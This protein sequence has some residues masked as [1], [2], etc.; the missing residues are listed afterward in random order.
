[1]RYW[2]KIK[3]I[4]DTGDWLDRYYFVYAW[5]DTVNTGYAKLN[6]ALSLIKTTVN[7]VY[8]VTEIRI[9]QAITQSGKEVE[10]MAPK[11]VRLAIEEIYKTHFIL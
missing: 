10:R 9:Q 2:W 6:L 4:R 1:M 8:W 7:H 11:I 5:Q 3:T